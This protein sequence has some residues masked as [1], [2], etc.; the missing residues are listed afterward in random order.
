MYFLDGCIMS[1]DV[2][3]AQYYVGATTKVCLTSKAATQG[4][5]DISHMIPFA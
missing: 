2:L 1:L 3:G 5:L 4:L